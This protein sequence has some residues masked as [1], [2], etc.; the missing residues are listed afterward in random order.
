MLPFPTGGNGLL[1][2]P[3]PSAY[4]PNASPAFFKTEQQFGMPVPHFLVAQHAAYAMAEQRR[5]DVEAH[6]QRMRVYEQQQKEKIERDR[7]LELQV[8]SR[9]RVLLG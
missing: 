7:E 6:E 5:R 3:T 9:V 4:H 8:R 1:P 2:L